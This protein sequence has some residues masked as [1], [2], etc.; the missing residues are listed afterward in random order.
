MQ[1]VD[2]IAKKRDGHALSRQEIDDF[3]QGFTRGEIPDYQ[4]AALLMAIV[5]KGMDAR[6]TADL[7]DAMTHS[8][9]TVDLSAVGDVVCDKHSTGGV[10]DTTTLILVPL[11]AACG[12][13]M[14]KMSGRG[15]GHTGGT[16]DKLES[17][18]GYRVEI[19]PETLVQL[20]R[21]N[22]AAIVGQTQALAPADKKLYALR[23]VTGTV[24]S[25]PLIASSVMSK[26]LAAGTDVIVLDVKTGSGAFMHTVED[27]FAL[28]RTMVDIGAHLGKRIAAIVTDM[29]QPLGNS[30]GNALDVREAIEILQGRHVDSPLREVCLLLG[31]QL[32]RMTGKAQTSV[33]A[34]AMLEQALRNGDALEKMRVMIQAQG[35]DARVCED[36]SLLGQASIIH[37]VVAPQSGYVARMQAAEIGMAAQMLGAG[38]MKK[39]DVIDPLVGIQMHVRVGDFVEKGQPL[40]DFYLNDTAQA[41][42]AEHRFLQAIVMQDHK[43]VAVPL[44]FGV[45]RAEGEER[46]FDA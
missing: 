16:L 10:G 35:G 23:D 44:V 1:M 26:K 34:R 9:Q 46:F 40:A 33:Q 43:P 7:T 39:E 17:I 27:S 8:G 13:K 42:Q 25:L 41:E 14:A 5:L 18:P 11:A 12:L 31:E 45:V 22:G 6:E 37:P 32:L 4:A 19:S 24:E 20:V 36:V 3:V 21:D 30:I 15:L 38:R 28:A 29:D 2:I